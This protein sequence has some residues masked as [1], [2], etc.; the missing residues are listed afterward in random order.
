MTNNTQEVFFQG[1]STTRLSC[2]K[3]EYLIWFSWS[4][5]FDDL[6]QSIQMNDIWELNDGDYITI[7]NRT[8]DL[9]EWL[10]LFPTEVG[11]RLSYKYI[12]KFERGDFPAQPAEGLNIWRPKT[13]DRL[14][15]GTTNEKNMI[16]KV[17][18]FNSCAFAIGENIR[19]ELYESLHSF[20]GF[21]KEE[22]PLNEIKMG[23]RA[24]D[25]VL[26]KGMPREYAHDWKLGK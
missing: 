13:G 21:T 9:P 24:K 5:I 10:E 16:K 20:G 18:L 6:K 19:V 23:R 7:S 11:G 2:R 4:N 12:K 22:R 3:G 26:E 8:E 14:V 25:L 17:F 15:W 1:D